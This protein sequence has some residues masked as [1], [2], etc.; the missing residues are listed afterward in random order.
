MKI[1][2]TFHWSDSK[3]VWN[4]IG[5]D[6]PRNSSKFLAYR[7]AEIE[8]NSMISNWRYVLT[9]Q[10]G[11]DEVTKWTKQ[12]S[13]KSSDRWFRGPAFLYEIEERWQSNLSNTITTVSINHRVTKVNR[14][15]QWNRSALMELSVVYCK[16]VSQCNFQ[17]ILLLSTRPLSERVLLQWNHVY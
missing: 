14:H 4:W 12:L 7:V 5:T 1:P 15:F 11:A 17:L 10:N 8:D 6:D 3:I 16:L 2:N 13:F 9:K